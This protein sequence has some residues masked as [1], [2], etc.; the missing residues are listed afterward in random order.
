MDFA[1]ATE[2]SPDGRNEDHVVLSAE[3]A[4]VLD[5]VTTLRGLDT[6]CRHGPRWYVRALGAHL[7]EALS[8]DATAG[9]DEVLAAAIE[10]VRARHAGTCDLTNPHSP[11]STVAIVRERDGY[12][13]Y[14]VLCDST[15][16]F[17]DPT[18]VVA[19]TDDRTATLPAYDRHSIARLRNRPGGFWVASTVPEAAAE[20]AT[21][22]VPAATVRRLL[23]C[24]DGVSR[25]VE[26]FGRDW[27]GV[28]DLVQRDGPRAAI[29]AVRTCE[30]RQPDRLTRAGR[31]TKQHDD[32]TL[33]VRL[34]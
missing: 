28:L 31:R 17:E 12:L 32:A 11:S 13:D 29:D 15:V 8:G 4:V 33:A 26:F 3:F 7:A 16:V 24:T 34:R 22:T 19:V 5:G 27:P 25:L 20:A 23:L 30:V 10:G 6:G 9:L 14:L 1:F 18:G 21:G 2:A